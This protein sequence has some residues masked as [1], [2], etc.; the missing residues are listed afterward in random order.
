[1]NLPSVEHWNL[2]V[3]PWYATF[4]PIDPSGLSHPNINDTGI[5]LDVGYLLA[6]CAAE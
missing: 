1:M 4:S 3:N 2:S 6:S 5:P